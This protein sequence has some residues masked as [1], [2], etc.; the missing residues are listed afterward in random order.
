MTDN[1]RLSAQKRKEF[2]DYYKKKRDKLPICPTCQSNS[3][4]VPTVRGKPSAELLL[5]AE[6]GNVKLSGCTRSYDGWCRKCEK[7]L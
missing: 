6:E 7:F 4:V 2:D 5:Y 3:D 1:R